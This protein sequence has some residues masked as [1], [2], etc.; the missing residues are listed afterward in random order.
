[1]VESIH[2][3]F[4]K[5]TRVWVLTSLWE[6]AV[7]RGWHQDF[8]TYRQAEFPT[9]TYIG[10]YFHGVLEHSHWLAAGTVWCQIKISIVIHLFAKFFDRLLSFRLRYN[11][12]MIYWTWTIRICWRASP[13]YRRNWD[14]NVRYTHVFRSRTKP[15]HDMLT[16]WKRLLS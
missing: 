16:T 8:L 9:A 5:M 3:P 1:M 14:M 2:M 15:W 7:L 11:R 10:I 12:R 4:G 13:S 6:G